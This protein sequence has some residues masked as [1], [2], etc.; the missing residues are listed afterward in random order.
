[1]ARASGTLLP[2]PALPAVVGGLVEVIPGQLVRA[3]SN[4][5][6]IVHIDN[7]SDVVACPDKL[8]WGVRYDH[9]CP[10]IAMGS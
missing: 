10:T 8:T 5:L 2:P 6:G 9:T 3:S 1:M 4:S 7:G